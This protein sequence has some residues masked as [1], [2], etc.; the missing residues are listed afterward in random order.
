MTRYCMYTARARPSR[1]ALVITGPLTHSAFARVIAGQPYPVTK[2]TGLGDLAYVTGP[3]P[4]LMAWKHGTILSVSV[5][6]TASPVAR[7]KRLA[8]RALGRL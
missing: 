6:G 2:V 4:L 3:H 5:S 7:A 8:R 1:S